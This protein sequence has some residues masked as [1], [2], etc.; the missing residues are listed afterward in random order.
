MH[1]NISTCLNFVLSICFCH[2]ICHLNV[3]SWVHYKIA[4]CYYVSCKII[5]EQLFIF[6]LYV[7]IIVKLVS[8]MECILL[9]SIL[10][11]LLLLVFPLVTLS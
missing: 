10:T 4:N 7:H 3:F 2:I 1:S 9:L 11:P 8:M 5:K 6:S